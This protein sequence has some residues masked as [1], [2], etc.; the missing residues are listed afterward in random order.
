MGCQGL[1]D[2]NLVIRGEPFSRSRLGADNRKKKI[3]EGN[4]K[5]PD[6]MRLGEAEVISGDKALF[7]YQSVKLLHLH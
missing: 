7:V 4:P 6:G 2:W 3:A 1:G 5:M